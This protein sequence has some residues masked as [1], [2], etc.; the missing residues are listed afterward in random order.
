MTLT[1]MLDTF[2]GPLDLLLHLIKQA[3]IDIYDIPIAKITSQYLD[4]LHQLQANA[5]EVAGDY[6]VM[7]ATLMNIK[8]KMLLPQIHPANDEND[9]FDSD[10]RD[11]LVAQLLTYQTYKNV[12]HDLAQRCQQRQTYFA[13]PPSMPQE[14]QSLVLKANAVKTNDLFMVI[15]KILMRQQQVKKKQFIHQVNREHF[16]V[17]AQINLVMNKLKQ[18]SQ[19]PFTQLLQVDNDVEEIVT[20]FLALLELMKKKQIDCQQTTY[21]D[22]IIITK[23]EGA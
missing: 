14:H 12:A 16:N 23:Y 2:E 17:K 9:D 22:E 10:P 20:T 18:V 6:L 8:S 11:D 7:A 5:L 4:Y 13:K 15:Q 19:L 3:K 21:Q 1:L